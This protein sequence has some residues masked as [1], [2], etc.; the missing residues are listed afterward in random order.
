MA[1]VD[2]AS[3]GDDAMAQDL[4]IEGIWRLVSSKAWNKDGEEIE[5]PYGTSPIGMISFSQG[6]L[7]AAISGRNPTPTCPDGPEYS[8][9]G[10]LYAFDGNTLRVQ[11]DVASDSSRIGGEQ[12]RDVSFDAG[13]MVLRPP[14]RSYGGRMEQRALIWEKVD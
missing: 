5:A 1:V 2:A 13:R 3:T 9:Y 11:V 4:S 6:R 10:G 7:L 8:S 12:V 14:L